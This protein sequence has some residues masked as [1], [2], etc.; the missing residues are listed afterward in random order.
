MPTR[1]RRST[2]SERLKL[3]LELG[4]AHLLA[5]E[6]RLD[7]AQLGDHHG[8]AVAQDRDLAGELVDLG[9]VVGELAREHSLAVL[10]LIE[11]RLALV[12]LR[13]QVLGEGPAGEREGERREHGAA[14]RH[15]EGAR[16]A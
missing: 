3:V 15:H 13:L 4:E 12:E 9:V 16:G 1:R 8:L 7:A 14:D 11:L 10:L 6:A 2:L 5:V